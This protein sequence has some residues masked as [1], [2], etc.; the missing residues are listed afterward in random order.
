MNAR[1]ARAKG[2]NFDNEIARIL[3]H[4]YFGVPDALIRT[5]GSR[6]RKGFVDQ[7]G[8]LGI[9]RANLPK[10]WVFAVEN[11]SRDRRPSPNKNAPAWTVEEL[12]FNS[13][14]ALLQYWKQC[15]TAGI[16]GKKIPLLVCKKKY[17]KPLIGIRK[18]DYDSLSLVI[19]PKLI[20]ND[21]VVFA[22]LELFLKQTTADDWI[23]VWRLHYGGS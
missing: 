2:R 5:H 6:S 13:D 9:A 23:D 11:K 15:R 8:D 10:P 20:L 21:S 18:R 7:V 17:Q 12:L 22:S 1:G 14:A 16:E 19:R 3:S 4:W